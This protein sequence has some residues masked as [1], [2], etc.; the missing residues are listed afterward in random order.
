MQFR[1]L[2]TLLSVFAVGLLGAFAE[3]SPWVALVT[4][5]GVYLIAATA[6]TLL[7][8]LPAFIFG[9]IKA[10]RTNPQQA[11]GAWYRAYFRNPAIV[12]LAFGLCGFALI[13]GSFTVYKTLVIRSG[14][15]H[16]DALFAALDR[17]LLGGTDAWVLTHA[18]FPQAAVTAWIDYIYHPAFLPMMI[19]YTACVGLRLRP[20]LRF[21]YMSTFLLGYVVVG[22]IA[23]HLL[24]SAGPVFDGI[25]F[26]DGQ[27]FGD[28]QT[29]LR[30]QSDPAAPLFA[31]RA[32]DY[33][34]YAY[35]EGIVRVGSGISA[36][37]SMHIVLASLWA[38]A[39]WHISRVLGVV[40][41]AYVALIWV[42]SVHLG[43][44]YFSDGLVSLAIIAAVW[45]IMGRRMGLY[46][47][48][49]SN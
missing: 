31:L 6:L 21:T 49:P 3:T 8:F 42:G 20:A 9:R 1:L 35:N 22:M 16:H 32:Q 34:L 14:G 2:V 18:L 39:A 46:R 27:T 4:T 11:G 7:F 23:A 36:M 38:F 40:L 12:D 47:Q 30:G 29:R 43:W 5:V 33:L 10:L 26:G 28:L 24:A 44:H 15:F 45:W 48:R 37:P 41:A 25:L 13:V 19:G 17:S